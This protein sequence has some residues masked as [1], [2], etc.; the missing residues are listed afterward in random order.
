MRTSV[1]ER[2]TAETNITLTL[3]LDGT[4]K[5]NVCSGVGFLDHMLTLFAAHSRFDLTLTCLGDIQVDDHHSAEDIGI[6]LGQALCEALG[7]KRGINRYAN[8]ILPMDESLILTAV[9]I[10]GRSCLCYDVDYPTEKIGT[11][12]VELIEEF[13]W[14][15]VRNCPMALHIKKMAGNN[16]HHI[17]VGVFK[18]VA[19]TLK[20]AVAIDPALGDEIPSTKGVI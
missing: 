18:S 8:T 20:A 17:A 14:A 12:D 3:K 11:F 7:A 19:R 9:D 15:F 13:W 10:S 6:C 16:S 4:G 1:I 2:K 5:S